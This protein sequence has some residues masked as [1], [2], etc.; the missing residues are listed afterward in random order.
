MGVRWEAEMDE[1]NEAQREKRCRFD[2]MAFAMLIGSIA[3]VA[4]LVWLWELVC[5][6]VNALVSMLMAV[7]W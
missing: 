2:A 4:V 6:G 5:A 3:V 7:Q 1:S